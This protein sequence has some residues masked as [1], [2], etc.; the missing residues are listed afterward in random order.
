VY[1][2]IRHHDSGGFGRHQLTPKQ[3]CFEKFMY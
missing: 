3:A 1:T 2:V